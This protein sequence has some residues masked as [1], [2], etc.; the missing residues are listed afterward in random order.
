MSDRG[1]TPGQ[2][3]VRELAASLLL[4]FAAAINRQ[5]EGKLLGIYAELR[6]RLEDDL[7]VVGDPVTGADLMSK[8]LSRNYVSWVHRVSKPVAAVERPVDLRF[9]RLWLP[10][11]AVAE[12][13]RPSPRPAYLGGQKWDTT[14]RALLTIASGGEVPHEGMSVNYYERSGLLTTGTGGNHR[15]LAHVLAGES[16]MPNLTRWEEGHQ[17]DPGLNDALLLVEEVCPHGSF[18]LEMSPPS[19]RAREAANVLGF[20]REATDDERKIIAAFLHH[21][22]DEDW[23]PRVSWIE[24][25]TVF[26]K[27][28]RTPIEVLTVCLS[29]LREIRGRGP[30]SPF[31]LPMRRMFGSWHPSLKFEE[32]LRGANPPG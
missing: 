24:W 15:L 3:R 16:R 22:L 23:W 32:W 25:E 14:M 9:D 2:R 31:L 10:R 13:E 27:V 6:A 21:H 11:Y 7:L 8:A 29:A 5:D 12:P 17:P 26:P 30:L 4:P 20:V 18:Y 28:A 1:L 19:V